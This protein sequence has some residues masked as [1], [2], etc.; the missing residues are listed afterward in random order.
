MQML[1][2]FQYSLA[3]TV[4]GEGF[5]FRGGA[6]FPPKPEDF[7]FGK[8][9][10]GLTEKLLADGSIK[11]HPLDVRQGGLDGISSGLADLREGRVSG[12]KLVYNIA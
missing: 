5:S 12:K 3:Y 11:V 10:W 6:E 2:S 4:T 1:I 9:F 7:E 8:K